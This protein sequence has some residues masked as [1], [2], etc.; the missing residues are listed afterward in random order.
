MN[1]EI[2]LRRIWGICILLSFLGCASSSSE[3]EI[4]TEESTSEMEDATNS[5]SVLGNNV[6]SRVKLGAEVLIESHLE[7]LS[8]KS[9]AVVAN[10]TSMVYDRVH[11]V[12]T[13]L[14]TGMNI[15]KVFSP[16]H[17]FRGTA[18][19]GEKVASGKDEE[20]G[21]PIVSLYGK[22]RKPDGA[23]L[24]EVE[25]VIFDIQDVGT[26]YY[27]YIST[28]SYVMEAC[29]ETQTE[30]V[31]L[32]RPN[33]NGWYVEGPIMQKAHQSF[34][35]LHEV[36][37]VHGMTITEYAAMVV[38][39]AWINEADALNIKLIACKGYE[40]QMKWEETGLTWIPPSP[41]LGTEYSAYLY[42]AI[43]WFEPTNVSVGRGTDDAFTLL[44]SP[45]FQPDTMREATARM[46]L[47]LLPTQFTPISLPGKSKYPKYQDELC[48][49]YTFEGRT[50]GK[51]LFLMSMQL[52][53]D[54]LV[55][56][57]INSKEAFF[58]K[59]FERWPGYD[60]FKADIRSGKEVED[61]WNDWQ[62]DLATFKEMRK[63]YL[64]YPN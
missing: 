25:V 23:E 53:R 2:N 11:L 39:E 47:Q 52:M 17:G 56:S 1:K 27:T 6:N 30:I 44:G 36:P 10:H 51:S 42:P 31:I 24:E 43:C 5:R 35:G 14:A 4:S 45:W 46:S 60:A 19:A 41:N 48:Y 12:D 63:A 18:D 3:K 32:D 33:P 7:E 8:G 38:G 26:R 16:E 57:E 34:I 61:I 37:V 62:G 20:T 49:G 13:L 29:A 28:M 9:I 55:Q 54:F 21:L 22:Q 15:V 40:H 50:D 64:M 58:K 59:G